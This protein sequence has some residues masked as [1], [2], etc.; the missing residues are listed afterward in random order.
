LTVL[1]PCNRS[2]TWLVFHSPNPIYAK[3]TEEKS[4]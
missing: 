1:V 2:G 4:G 3:K